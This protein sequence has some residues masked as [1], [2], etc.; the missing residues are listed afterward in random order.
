MVMVMYLI[1]LLMIGG[2]GP[3]VAVS[4]DRGGVLSADRRYGYG[5]LRVSCPN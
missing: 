2:Y 5:F 1:D 3:L 4:A